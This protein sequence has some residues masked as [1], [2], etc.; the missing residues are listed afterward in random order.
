[1]FERFTE[2]ARAV[3][4]AA[5]LQA[6][7]MRHDSIGTEHLLLAMLGQP[8]SASGRLLAGHGLTLEQ[9]SAA[10]LA[11]R[12]GHGPDGS[13][14]D[15]LDAEALR[16]IGIDLDAV[17]ASVEASFGEGALAGPGARPGRRGPGGHIPF[18]PRA[19]KALELGLREAIR[20]RQKEIRD[21]HLLLGI[22]REGEGLAALVLVRA[23]L[24]LAAL[25]QEIETQLRQAG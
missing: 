13:G 2:D 22:L 8:V 15:D 25:R 14:A 10:V 1:M 7:T 6:R 18:T 4:V 16:A 17:R 19:K 12:G 20:L 3:V 11:F 5:Q 9:A 21:L 23:G 24:D